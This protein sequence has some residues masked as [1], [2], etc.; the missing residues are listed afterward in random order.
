[1]LF[2]KIKTKKQTNHYLHSTPNHKLHTV[3][4]ELTQQ[5]KKSKFLNDSGEKKK[6]G[7]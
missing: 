1:M 5:K 4:A 7:V 6:I 3:S 2:F